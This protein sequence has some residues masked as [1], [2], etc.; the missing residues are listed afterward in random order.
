VTR[1]TLRRR[2]VR[3]LAAGLALTAGLAATGCE[4]VKAGAAAVVGQERLATSELHATV[5]QITEEQEKAGGGHGDA[6]QLQRQVLTR[7]IVGV[8]VDEAAERRDLSVTRG[9]VDARLDQLAQG[10]GGRE[11]FE[12][13]V[14]SDGVSPDELPGLIRQ[15]LLIEKLG[16]QL[17]P[18]SGEQVQVQRQQATGR[19]LTR[20]A[21]EIG[22]TVSPRFGTWD[23]QRAQLTPDVND[24]SRPAEGGGGQGG[25]PT[26]VTPQE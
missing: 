5:E 24:L 22:V 10:V 1:T 8:I 7:Q 9:E 13:A 25:A 14:V 3:V 11:K 12:K 26:P 15:T 2:T 21:R 19:V 23:P 6:A 4:P 17:V 18:G 20:I 16:E